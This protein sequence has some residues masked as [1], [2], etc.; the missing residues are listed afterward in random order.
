MSRLKGLLQGNPYEDVK[1]FDKGL[2][3][4]FSNS[5]ENEDQTGC[6]FLDIRD[7]WKDRS[8]FFNSLSEVFLIGR[9]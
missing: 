3:Q 6:V 4:K 2:F 1:I 7:S 8:G 5:Q 9:S